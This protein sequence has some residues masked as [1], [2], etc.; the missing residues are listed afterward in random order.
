MRLYDVSPYRLVIQVLLNTQ[1]V[2]QLCFDILTH[3]SITIA[4]NTTGMAHLK[5]CPKLMLGIGYCVKVQ[6]TY[7]TF[8]ELTVL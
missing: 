7:K 6:M 4:D 5:V 1:Q 3:I 2:T 8:R